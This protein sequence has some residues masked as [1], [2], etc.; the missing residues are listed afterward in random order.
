[1]WFI[2]ELYTK[3]VKKFPCLTFDIG[4]ILYNTGQKFGI[5]FFLKHFWSRAH[6]GCIELTQN[7]VKTEILCIVLQFKMICSI[8]MFFFPLL[9]YLKIHI[10]L[11]IFSIIN[12]VFSV[13]CSFVNICLLLLNKHFLLF[14]ILKTHV[15]IVIHP[16]KLCG[17]S[18][19]KRKVK[20]LLFSNLLDQDISRHL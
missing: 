1:M 18:L 3:H 7:A 13:A 5:I 11:W 9:L 16:S 6:Q 20:K 12:S 15:E 8:F 2:T 17:K 19:K 14:S 4:Y 10:F